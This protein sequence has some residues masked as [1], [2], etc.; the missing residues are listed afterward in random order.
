[1]LLVECLESLIRIAD[2]TS[3]HFQ[4]ADVQ[5]FMSCHCQ[6][7]HLDAMPGWGGLLVQFVG[8][9]SGG[10]E[11]DLIQPTL[12]PTGLGQQEMGEMD[13]V[14]G[15]PEDAQAWN[16]LSRHGSGFFAKR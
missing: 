2:A 5:G 10:H 12:F 6:P 3:I 14:E 1:M 8:R 4:R 13:W 7:K 15:P 9:G 16:E 11:P